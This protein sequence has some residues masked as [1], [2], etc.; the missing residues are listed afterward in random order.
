MTRSMLS[1]SAAVVLALLL[2]MHV[3]TANAAR[4][5]ELSIKEQIST[6]GGL[7]CLSGP[8]FCA[9]ES[10][11]IVHFCPGGTVPRKPQ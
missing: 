11:G 2:S 5:R 4:M 7:G 1:V 3:K 8:D 6:C 9:Y 10:A